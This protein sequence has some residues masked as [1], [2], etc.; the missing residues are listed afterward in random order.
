M[1]VAEFFA[2]MTGSLFLEILALGCAIPARKLSGGLHGGWLVPA[3]IIATMI[4]FG[5]DIY[6]QTQ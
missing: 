6:L 1:G 5:V 3:I 2:G 4:H